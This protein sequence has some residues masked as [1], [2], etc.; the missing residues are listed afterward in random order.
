MLEVLSLFVPARALLPPVPNELMVG[1]RDFDA[2]ETVDDLLGLYPV[3]AVCL[4]LQDGLTV[5]LV[6]IPVEREAR[7]FRDLTRLRDLYIL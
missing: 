5:L 3:C 6:P 4:Q 1:K 2:N 7:S